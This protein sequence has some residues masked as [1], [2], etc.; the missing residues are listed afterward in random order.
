MAQRPF[1]F[2]ENF[3]AN[4]VGQ[5]YTVALII[6]K[7]HLDSLT[8]NNADPDI[9]AREAIFQIVYDSLKN[10]AISKAV[11]IGDRIDDTASLKDQFK[12]IREVDLPKWQNLIAAIY[13]RRSTTFK[14][15]FPQG[16]NTILKGRIDSKITAVGTLA[17]ATLAKPALAAVSAMITGRFNSLTTKRN[18]QL[19][20]KANITG[21]IGAQVLAIAAMCDAHF[22]DH[23]LVITKYSNNP[24]KIASFI[25]V[26]NIQKH[27]HD[28]TYDGTVNGEKT[29][30]ALV[31][32][33]TAAS[34]F[35]VTVTEK[36]QIWVIDK[37]NNPVK[38]A[39][40]T[41]MANTPTTVSF[42]AAGNPAD[43]VVQLKNLTTNKCT[44]Q[45]IVS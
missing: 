26:V 29:K 36:C 33:F 5:N 1:L 15:F 14:G 12:T 25:D 28:S 3:I 2:A 40:V 44:Y 7:Y 38:P 6:G 31:H 23:G 9:A 8:A 24:A 19:G 43:R 30:T 4:A 39:G 20:E 37:S 22:I 13:P 16:T 42:P 11:D 10:A 35:S 34:T 18:E 21:T 41:I 27:V 17:S 45:I 32:K